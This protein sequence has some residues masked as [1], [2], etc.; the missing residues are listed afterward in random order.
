MNNNATGNNSLPPLPNNGVATPAG[1]SNDSKPVNNTQPTS[2]NNALPPLPNQQQQQPQQMAQP[3]VAPAP[4]QKQVAAQQPVANPNNQP[5]ANPNSNIDVVTEAKPQVA[6]Q[7]NTNQTQT[8]PPANQ[9]VQVPK[10]PT[11]LVNEIK[12]PSLQTQPVAPMANKQV[13]SPASPG[14]ANSTNANQ[15]KGSTQSSFSI[16]TSFL[17]LLTIIGIITLVVYIAILLVPDLRDP[18]CEQVGEQETL[19]GILSCG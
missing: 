8:N 19:R 3:A 7:P 13:T 4:V 12:G 17:S 10:K 6:N 14:D 15:S 18:L 5:V 1:G 2:G 9:Q 16:I 11:G